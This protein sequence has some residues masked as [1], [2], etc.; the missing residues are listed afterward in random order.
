MNP[1]RGNSSS[2][3]NST[4]QPSALW[5][6]PG[7]LADEF[8][9]NA[10]QPGEVL[11]LSQHLGFERPLARGH[12]RA[13]VPDLLRTDQAEG[14]TG[15]VEGELKRPVLFLTQLVSSCGA[16]SLRSNPHK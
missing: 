5:T 13:T 11:I 2:K 14:R 4:L 10:G 16:S 15:G 8:P 7:R 12:G 6:L 9:V 3:W 1:T